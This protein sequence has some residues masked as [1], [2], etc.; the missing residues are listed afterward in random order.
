M[1]ERGSQTTGAGTASHQGVLGLHHVEDDSLV[2][3]QILAE[4]G[5]RTP[6]FRESHSCHRSPP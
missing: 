4:A 2:P 6:G 1:T 5:Q 3:G